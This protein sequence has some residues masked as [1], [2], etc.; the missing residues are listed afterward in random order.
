[1][2]IFYS[3]IILGNPSMAQIFLDSL[4]IP[5][6]YEKLGGNLLAEKAINSFKSWRCYRYAQFPI[7]QWKQF[8][9]NQ[10]GRLFESWLV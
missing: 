6:N 8:A 9:V 2:I 10:A 4:I 5:H 1:M 3:S 7:Q